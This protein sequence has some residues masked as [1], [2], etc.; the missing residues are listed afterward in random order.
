[1]VDP[2]NP[3]TQPPEKPWVRWLKWLV[4]SGF[5]G[6]LVIA[7]V[8][9]WMQR[10]APPTT[11]TPP[12]SSAPA[13]PLPPSAPPA[14]GP[15]SSGPPAPGPQPG[16]VQPTWPNPVPTPVPTVPPVPK[17]AF[18]RSA[19]VHWYSIVKGTGPEPATKHAVIFV[20]PPGGRYHYGQPVTFKSDGTWESAKICF[21]GPADTATTFRLYA[22]AV[23]ADEARALDDTN[24]TDFAVDAPYGSPLA[25]GEVKRDGTAGSCATGPW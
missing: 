2:H 17:F 24:G 25:E 12:A 9:V 19:P 5:L 8:P 23:T 10:A 6:L 22:R 11:T 20:Q 21:G 16:P 7:V 18:D 13:T 15:G 14:T 1:M 4:P 3:A